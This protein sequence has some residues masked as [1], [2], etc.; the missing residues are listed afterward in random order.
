[1]ILK[2][3]IISRFNQVFYKQPK[4]DPASVFASGLASFIVCHFGSNAA[5]M[6]YSV[7]HHMLVCSWTKGHSIT[8]S[9]DATREKN[10]QML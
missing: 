7:I 6:P 2:E 8:T 3:F 9:Q 5:H 10:I 1:M 4:N